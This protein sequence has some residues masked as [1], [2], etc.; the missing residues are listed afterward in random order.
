MPLKLS[1]KIDVDTDRG[2][3]LGVPHLCEILAKRDI[4]ATFLFSLGPDN[5]GRA[6][7][8]IFRPGF[9][10]KVSRTSVL[11]VYGLKTLLN[12]I[13]W[14]GPLIGTRHKALIKAVQEKGHEV[15]IHCYDHIRWQDGLSKMSLQAV[16]EEIQK[17]QDIFQN[18]FQGPSKTRGAA[19]W[20]A[21]TYSL[22][23]YD[24][25][26]F[27]YGSDARGSCP[28]FP[29]IGEKIFKTL[30]VPT[31]LPTLDELLGRPDYPFSQISAFLFEKFL[32]QSKQYDLPTQVL[33]I[34]AELEG[35]LYADWFEGVLDLFQN[36]GI[37]FITNEEIAQTWL[38]NPAQIPVCPV[39][40]DS[41]GGRSG[42]L[43]CQGK[44]ISSL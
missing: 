20:Q 37:Q 17:S 14:P 9:L 8:R 11:K 34:H 15:G 7:K 36:K 10:K 18:I 33:T 35:M 38:K 43:A 23:A 41:I 4:R 13:L 27:L 6:L 32:L 44:S 3:R 19:G 42:T 22:Q 30:Q 16:Q 21:N 2:T 39:L 29:K 26:S 5:T 31:T 28:F 12:G 24:E 40:E 25:Q 1:L